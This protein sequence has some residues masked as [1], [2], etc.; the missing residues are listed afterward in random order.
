MWES[1]RETT[2]FVLRHRRRG[3]AFS[4]E[5]VNASSDARMMWLA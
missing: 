2:T 1:I 5:R 4:R 3:V